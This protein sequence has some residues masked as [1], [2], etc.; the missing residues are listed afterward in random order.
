MAMAEA[1]FLMD[2]S[3]P[4][5]D[6]EDFKRWTIAVAEAEDAAKEIKRQQRVYSWQVAIFL[7]FV[8]IMCPIMI[9]LVGFLFGGILAGLMGWPFEDGFYYIVTS[10]LGM[11]ITLTDKNPYGRAALIVSVLTTYWSLGLA[12]VVVGFIG[13]LSATKRNYLKVCLYYY[14]PFQPLTLNLFLSLSPS[15]SFFL[16]LFF[17]CQASTEQVPTSSDEHVRP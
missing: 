5:E 2:G 10:M 17:Y 3:Y 6:M 1:Q 11:D 13:E 8:I 4:Y 9:L 16:F 15:L 12:I 7:T 14:S